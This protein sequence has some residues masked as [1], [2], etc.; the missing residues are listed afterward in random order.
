MKKLIYAIASLAL[1]LTGCNKEP[2]AVE[3]PSQAGLEKVTVCAELPMGP[4]TKAMTYT[5]PDG[6][7]AQLDHWV[8]EVRDA[9]DVN[10]VYYHGEKAGEKG[11]LT[12]TFDLYLVKGHTYYIAFWADKAGC[13][14]TDDLNAIKCTD[15]TK[16]GNSDD[17]DGF[18]TCLKYEVK[19]ND[20][21]SAKLYRPFAQVNVITNDLPGLKSTTTAEAYSLYEPKDFTFKVTVPTIYNAF[22]STASGEQEIIITPAEGANHCYGDYQAAEE[23]TTIHMVYLLANYYEGKTD[24]EQKDVR[25]IAFGFNSYSVKQSY[26]LVNIPLKRNFRTNIIGSFLTNTVKWEV[27][28]IPT[29]QGEFE[30]TYPSGE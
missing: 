1:I 11:V 3:G 25:N 20:V 7:G 24:L 19:G 21:V 5:Y 17:F 18:S 6:N 9:L 10:K 8:V 28:V 16:I 29:W 13:Y 23:R 4:E 12:Q 14:N 15:I 2:V 27:E 30:E 26:D 22:K